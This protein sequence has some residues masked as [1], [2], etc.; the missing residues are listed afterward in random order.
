L[1]GVQQ[2]IRIAANRPARFPRRL[3]ALVDQLLQQIPD[4]SQFCGL[5]LDDGCEIGPLDVAR[6]EVGDRLVARCR[7]RGVSRPLPEEVKQPSGRN[8]V[9]LTEAK[10]RDRT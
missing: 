8:A 3:E 6:H 10:D 9:T 5:P 7:R 1:L 4:P 2:F